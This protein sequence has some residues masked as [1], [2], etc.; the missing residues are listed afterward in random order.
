MPSSTLAPE[1][2]EIRASST[3]GTLA[4]ALGLL[5]ALALSACSGSG[6][7]EAA[8]EM[9]RAQK[10]SAIAEM[11]LPGTQGVRGALDAVSASEARAEAHDTI[12]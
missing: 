11:P 6:D 7:E 10:D 9:T 4:L 12:R 3:G 5:G 2:T 1:T 8:T